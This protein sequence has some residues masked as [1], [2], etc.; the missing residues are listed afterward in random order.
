VETWESRGGTWIAGPCAVSVGARR[1]ALF[2][3]GTDHA[4]YVRWRTDGRWDDWESLG[5]MMVAA[6]YAVSGTGLDLF[7]VS[8]DHS[9]CYRS[10]HDGAWRPWQPL[11]A[12][13]GGAALT[14]PEAVWS[15]TGRLDAVM[16]AADLQVRHRQRADD[17]WTDWGRLP[18]RMIGPPRAVSRTD[19]TVDVIGPGVDGRLYH[20]AQK[21]GAWTGWAPIDDRTATSSPT[22]VAS[23]PDRLDV[24]FLGV[25]RMLYHCRWEGGWSTGPCL[26]GT[27]TEPPRA[28]FW[29]EVGTDIFAV[30]EDRAIWYRPLRHARRTWW[31]SL[32][33]Q[34][35]SG[36]S[37][38]PQDPGHA[39]IFVLGRDSAVWHRTFV[40]L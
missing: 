12:E 32:G 5:G 37:L 1:L 39:E 14:P 25:D 20:A 15:G 21:G 30:G 9:V 3:V 16:L 7:C 2:C 28:A 35:Y 19:G 36:I 26:E 27:I 22:V 33:G 40:S 17:R 24:Y 18:G 38:V 10:W 23:G 6:P 31:R 34:A 13:A 8:Q 29:P 4:V 11:R